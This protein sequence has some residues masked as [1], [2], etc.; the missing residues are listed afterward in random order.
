MLL[1]G[2]PL[3]RRSKEEVDAKLQVCSHPAGGLK[4]G[5][6]EGT[7]APCVSIVGHRW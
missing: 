6:L 1:T 3:C 4:S 2:A 7:L 5:P